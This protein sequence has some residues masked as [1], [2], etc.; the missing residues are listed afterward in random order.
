MEND[1]RLI[2][3]E[4]FL[5]GKHLVKAAFLPTERCDHAHCIFC[6]EK[7][8]S[9]EGMFREGSHTLEIPGQIQP[10]GRVRLATWCNCDSVRRQKPAEQPGYL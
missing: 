10:P 7:F 8:G 3:Q 1:W 2:G 5:Q 4:R 6:W 9:G